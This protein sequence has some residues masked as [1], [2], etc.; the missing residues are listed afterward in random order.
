MWRGKDLI[1]ENI[2]L[3]QSFKNKNKKNTCPLISFILPLFGGAH[4]GTINL[5][6]LGSFSYWYLRNINAMNCFRDAP[7]CFAFI[8]SSGRD[9]L[10]WLI[11][12]PIRYRSKVF[13]RIMSWRDSIRRK[14]S[15]QTQTHIRTLMWCTS[16]W[17]ETPHKM[18][19]GPN[20]KWPPLDFV[21]GK[22]N[23]SFYLRVNSHPS[24]KLSGLNKSFIGFEAFYSWKEK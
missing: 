6:Y 14:V 24:L 23:I 19:L 15:S 7:N 12:V 17:I 16:L 1:Y 2:N 9:S 5:I 22:K 3:T 20:F 4:S 13:H 11:H 21:K 8:D 10:G 18:K